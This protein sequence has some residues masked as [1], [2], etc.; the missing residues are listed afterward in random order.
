NSDIGTKRETFFASMLEV[1][2]TLH[3]VQKG[4]FLINEK[5]T[6]EIGGKNKGYGQIKDI[7]DAFIAVD[8][9]ETGFANKIPL[10][11]FGFLY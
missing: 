2:H 1:G 6:V 3:Y 9:I 7:P 11:L 5:Y 10:W 8:G 4:D